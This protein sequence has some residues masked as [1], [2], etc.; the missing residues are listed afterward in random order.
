MS[1]QSFICLKKNRMPVLQVVSAER[2]H[3]KK[4]GP[5]NSQLT[6]GF[7]FKS[8]CFL[9]FLWEYTCIYTVVLLLRLARCGGTCDQFVVVI[10]MFSFTEFTLY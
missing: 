10:H 5:V 2:S 1:S 4:M 6:S 7:P 8:S 9:I 3:E